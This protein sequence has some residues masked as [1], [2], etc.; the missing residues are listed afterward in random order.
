MPPGKKLGYSI[1][2]L[3]FDPSLI[4]NTLVIYHLKAHFKCY[5]S[6]CL[7]LHFL[8]PIYKELLP[9]LHIKVQQKVTILPSHY[10]E[11]IQLE[12]LKTVVVSCLHIYYVCTKFE[13]NLEHVSIFCVDLTWNDPIAITVTHLWKGINVG[14]MHS[15][16]LEIVFQAAIDHKWKN[17]VRI[18]IR[19]VKAHSSQT[20]N[21]WVTEVFHDQALCK[22]CLQFLL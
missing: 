8:N 13:K 20:Q 22:E 21:I 16:I 5:R 9:T 14:Y 10:L 7:V 4:K 19:S 15:A 17:K 6:I 1:S 12:H 2:D 3:T 11:A 18:S